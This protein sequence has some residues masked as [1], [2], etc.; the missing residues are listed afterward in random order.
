MVTLEDAHALI[1]AQARDFG[2]EW[3][4]LQDAVGR[5]L[6]TDIYTDRDYPPFNRAAVDGY[7]FQKEDWD[8]GIREFRCIE[9]IFA[10]EKPQKEIKS[11]ECYKIMTGSAVPSPANVLIKIEDANT[12]EDTITFNIENVSAFENIALKGED[13][14][15]ETLIISKNTSLDALIIGSLAVVGYKSVEVYSLPKVTVISTGNE[16]K[17]LGEPVS[18]VEIRDS[19]SY[20]LEAFLKRFGIIL[21]NKLLIPDD[22]V[23]LTEAIEKALATSDILILSGGVSAGDADY[24]PGI[25]KEQGVAEIFHKVNIKPGKPLW[26]GKHKSGTIVFG[27]PG[28]PFSVQVGYKLFI[29]PFLN[30]CLHQDPINFYTVPLNKE[31]VKKSRLNEF[32]PCILNKEDFS[33]TPSKFNGSGD[34]SAALFTNGIG[35]HPSSIQELPKYSKVR[36]I[37]W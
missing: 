25:L 37:F 35:F 13:R 11:G 36:F 7:A 8:T 1:L 22:P 20:V 26:F 23:L 34:I 27:L 33:I 19:N 17:P 5:V 9:H 6:A 2:T 28:N 31:R 15:A 18:D 21:E 30:A 24:V 29:E 12:L 14:K 3:V 10:G 4:S 32:F 16:V